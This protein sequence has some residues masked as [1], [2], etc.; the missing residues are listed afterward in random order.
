MIMGDANEIIYLPPKEMPEAWYNVL[1]DLPEPLPP[2]K[3]PETGPSRIKGMAK[4]YVNKCLEYDE[5][6]KDKWIPIPEGVRRAYLHA[7]RPT[8]LNRAWRLEK[9]LDTPAHIYYKREGTSPTGSY[10]IISN[11]AQAVWAKQEGYDRL[12][13][14]S[15][16]TQG[17]ALCYA[18]AVSGMKAM[19]FID[20]ASYDS[21][22]GRVLHYKQMGGKVVRSP[23]DTTEIGRQMRKEDPNQPGSWLISAK[24]MLELFCGEKV[25]HSA[26]VMGSGNTH[27]IL[28]LTIMGLE[29]KKQ[30]EIAGEDGPDIIVDC[31]AAGGNWSGIC[32]PFVKDRLDGKTKTRFVA[33][34]PEGWACF[35]DGEY[36]YVDAFIMN[37]LAKVYSLGWRENP[38]Q[39]QAKGLMIP[40]G[41]II[42]SYLRQKGLMEAR[43]YT[44]KDVA[45]ATLEW[46][47]TE[48]YIPALEASYA[49][50][51][52][53]DEAIK[54]REEGRRKVIVINISGHGYYDTEGYA[55]Y[56]KM[57]E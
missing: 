37:P 35:S 36:E 54:A 10:K 17:S 6:Y 11:L 49:V 27:N 33:C 18:A 25:R 26:Y 20:A 45:S 16:G 1:P 41:A 12:L 8:P 32:L 22:P 29:L 30:L 19:V 57:V 15:A 28:F 55:S 3:D 48:G 40:V 53:I 9:L 47:R 4:I 42:P 52:G 46:I 44:E 31:A 50:K 2:L 43:K 5:N 21:R 56:M 34:Q 14:C 39:I 13:T 24:E 38:P 7:G 23:S 51:G